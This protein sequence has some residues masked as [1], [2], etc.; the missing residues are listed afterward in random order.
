M[1]VSA[2]AAMA[3]RNVIGHNNQIPW[4]LPA[5]LSYFKRTTL[6]HHILMGRNSFQGIG[7]PLPNRTNVV[8]TRNAFFTA[9]GVLVAHSIEDALG[10]AYDHG[11]TE[12]FIIG[13]G[14]IFEEA[15]DLLDKIYIT[16]VDLDVEGDA[17]FPEINPTEWRE[18]WREAHEPDA[19]NEHKYVFRVLERIEEV[20]G[21]G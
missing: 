5:D 16:E 19:K 9:D 11:E 15:F 1:I 10:I 14:V 4:Y 8:I 20:E 17:F 6:N 21:G 7:H 12:A 13:G 18:V 2:I 3:H